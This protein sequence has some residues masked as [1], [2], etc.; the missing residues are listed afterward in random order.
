[1]PDWRDHPC[2]F[3]WENI[4]FKFFG[5]L[6][7]CLGCLSRA[8]CNKNKT[9]GIKYSKAVPICCDLLK[10]LLEYFSQKGQRNPT[11]R[12]WKVTI[13]FRK[14]VRHDRPLNTRVIRRIYSLH[15]TRIYLFCA[16]FCHLLGFWLAKVA[17]KHW[18]L[19]CGVEF[20]DFIAHW[21]TVIT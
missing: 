17:G 20:C 15:V 2:E 6:G 14:F 9:R 1:M 10:G 19:M 18:F 5:S 8:S 16:W 13:R 12:S 7:L 11:S 21:S 3:N 4:V